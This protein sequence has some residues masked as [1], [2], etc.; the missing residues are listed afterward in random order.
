MNGYE[1]NIAHFPTI[2]FYFWLLAVIFTSHTYTRTE[3]K[4][5]KMLLY[6]ENAKND[7]REGIRK[8][9]PTM[10][11]YSKKIFSF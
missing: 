8:H 6:I 10:T 5:S 1:Q 7:T 9:I 4:V 3:A 2:F 11:N